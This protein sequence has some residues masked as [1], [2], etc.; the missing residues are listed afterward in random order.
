MIKSYCA[1]NK[2]IYLDYF[3]EMNDGKN[4]MIAEYTTDGVHCT[5]KGYDKMESMVKPA[6]EKALKSKN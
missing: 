3:S 4:G 1:K 5:S 6:I 2:V